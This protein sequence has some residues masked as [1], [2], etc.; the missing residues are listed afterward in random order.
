MI[1]LAEREDDELASTPDLV[2]QLVKVTVQLE[3]EDA[4]NDPEII[5]HAPIG[6]I[7][8]SPFPPAMQILSTIH[9]RKC[10]SQ[11][12]AKLANDFYVRWIGVKVTILA[13]LA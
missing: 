1:S 11:V 8:E 10:R 13:S 6:D 2:N 9:F 5:L 3:G 4:V 7:L 12:G